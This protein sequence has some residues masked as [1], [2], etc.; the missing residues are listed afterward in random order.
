MKLTK[1]ISAAVTA[2]ALA[3][4]LL[5]VPF[6]NTPFA[7]GVSVSAA[8]KA[9]ET[10]VSEYA[11]GTASGLPDSSELERLYIEQ[12]FYGESVSLYK[13][14]GQNHL[15]GA[16]LEIYTLLRS[17]I[18]AVAD[19]DLAKTVFSISMAEAFGGAED[20]SVGVDRA[21]QALMADLPSSFYWYDKTVGYSYS[22]T[23]GGTKVT[24]LIFEVSQDYRLANGATQ[25][26]NYN[27]GSSATFHVEADT[28]KISKAKTAVQAAQT[29]LNK[30]DGDS[31]YDKIIGYCKEICA[32]TD[33]NHD[34]ANDDNT[35]YGDPWQLVWVFDD[36]P[37]TKVV[38]EGYS[39]AFQYLCDMSGI[40]CYTVSGD[41]GGAHMWNIVVLDGENYLVDVT[42]CDGDNGSY[43]LDWMIKGV[44]L[45]TSDGFT[46]T[47]ND[48]SYSRTYDED[49]LALYPADILT[50]ATHDYG[51]VTISVTPQSQI[52]SVG[53]EFDVTVEVTATGDLIGINGVLEWDYGDAIS[54]TEKTVGEVFT[55][56]GLAEGETDLIFTWKPA[57][58]SGVTLEDGSIGDVCAVTVE[59]AECVHE[60]SDTW[61]NDETG[62]WHECTK[63]GAKGTVTDHTESSADNG[64][65]ATCTEKGRE[66]DTICSVCKF[67]IETGKEIPAK[68]HTGGD[69][70]QENVKDATCTVAGSYEEVVYC[71]V[72]NEEI[73]RKHVTGKTLPHDLEEVPGSAKEPTCAEAGKEA[74]QKCKNCDYTETGAAIPATGEHDYETVRVDEKPATCTEEGSY[75]ETVKCKV[76]GNIKSS[77]EK[78]I[79]KIPHTPG[80]AVKENEVAAAC[81]K[82]GSYDMVTR[83]TV[84]ENVTGTEH[85]VIPALGHV[86]GTLIPGE[87]THYYQCSRCNEK[88]G[89]APHVKDAGKV[90]V[91]PTA[92]TDGV[93]TYSCGECGKVLDTE[94]IPA[95]GENHEHSYSI[96]NSDDANHWKE[97]ECGEIDESTKASHTLDQKEE[98][99]L[100]PTCSTDGMKNVITYCTY[101]GKETARTSETVSA[102]DNH[103]PDAEY[104]KDSD[105]HWKVCTICGDVINKEAHNPGLAATE[106]T[107]QTCT[108]CG[109]EMAPVLTHTHKFAE[110]WTSNDT[111]HWHAAVCEHT[112]EVSDK[113]LHAWD[114]GVITTKPTETSKGVKTFT[115]GVCGATKTES[116]SELTHTHTPGTSWRYD[117]T[118]HWHECGS[119]SEKL[120]FAGHN[121]VSEITKPPLATV[122][123]TRRYYCS[124]CKYII[125]EET[126]PA[127]GTVINPVYP[128]YPWGGAAVLPSAGTNEPKLDNGSGK[129]GWESIADD[130]AAASDGSA[131]YV[132]MNGTTTLSR[133]ALREIMGKNVD[134]V[135]E[136]NNM[137]TWTVNGE[138]VEKASDVN[139]KARL[140]TNGIPENVINEVSGGD[141]VQLRLSHSGSF[142]FEAVMTVTL[143]TKYNGMFANLMYY[144]PKTKELEF[145]DCS[146]ISGGKAVL[147]FS[148]ASDYAIIIGSEPMGAYEDVSAAAGVYENDSLAVSESALYAVIISAVSIAAAIV[149]F[150]KRVRK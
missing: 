27:D 99:V 145:V 44:D 72:C 94:T 47:V 135:L 42:W 87:T 1:R 67:V 25:T 71:E 107:P 100:E 129:S 140:N 117:A 101:C 103:I 123:G 5:A 91:R 77:E 11:A 13:D 37:N 6:E 131:V 10:F 21:I 39:K 115:C 49:V 51:S 84:C 73:S 148:H 126:I 138:T 137:I 108:V 88:I 45:N 132:D 104:G 24:R 102:T 119:C 79:A 32:L 57:E 34:A 9:A 60:W 70:V 86:L 50:L 114:N 89:E 41:A 64:T 150:K 43:S 66:A 20:L 14:Y 74:D 46:L 15:T 90:T 4:G 65:E 106:T 121:E 22:Y 38:C 81:T 17:K 122:T 16:E 96:T 58:D 112:E 124:I 118:G 98:T 62:H 52:I 143:G 19:G 97:C 35:P 29:I 141:A 48:I 146:L 75:K 93:R 53:E 120:D 125:R 142:G 149:I 33:Y 116:V 7:G 61:E 92:D 59:A 139:M 40:E 109:Y 78:T 133:L 8:E 12:L 136:M 82:A 55:V 31:D 26:V 18:E 134:L 2:S 69:P 68:G 54:V 83:C 95:L 56:K 127:T 130:I 28:S 3:L 63:C 128:S 36:D 111:H 144:N 30:Y 80:T 105:N 85:T 23:N 113:A 147:D 110:V 76:C